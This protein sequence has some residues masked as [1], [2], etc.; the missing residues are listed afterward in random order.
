MR[1]KKQN[2]TT[3]NKKKQ[4]KTK[5]SKIKDNKTKTKQKKKVESIEKMHYKRNQEFKIERRSNTKRDHRSGIQRV[6]QI[7]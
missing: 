3:Q 2:E 1:S 7:S 6:E 4:E 5:Q